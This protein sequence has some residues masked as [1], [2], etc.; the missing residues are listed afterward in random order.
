M[1]GFDPSAPEAYCYLRNEF[2]EWI[3][4]HMTMATPDRFRLFMVHAQQILE[5]L[6]GLKKIRPKQS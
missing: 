4:S 3:S 6:I 2:T 5:L 1:A